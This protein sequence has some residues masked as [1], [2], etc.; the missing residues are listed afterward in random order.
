[1]MTLSKSTIFFH[2]HMN[3]EFASLMKWRIDAQSQNRAIAYQ[4]RVMGVTLRRA[5]VPKQPS[6]YVPHTGAKEGRRY[7]G[8]RTLGFNASRALRQRAEAPGDTFDKM[9]QTI[10]RIGDKLKDI[11]EQTEELRNE[12]SIGQIVTWTSSNLEKTGKIV[13]VVQPGDHP[14][15]DL[16]PKVKPGAARDH[17]SYVV[18]AD[19]KHYWPR[20]S[21]LSVVA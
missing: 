3:T 15:A 12:S 13:A 17:V 1:M 6:R 7:A 16:K 8:V 9:H 2:P 10:G 18:K 19:G 4:E 21:L 5:P 20:V 11:A 14:S